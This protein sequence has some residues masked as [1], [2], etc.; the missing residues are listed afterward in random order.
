[1]KRRIVL[2]SLLLLF[3]SSIGQ[4]QQDF[5]PANRFGIVEGFWFPDVTCDLGVGW[6][7]IIFDWAQHQ[8]TGP[9]DWHTLNVDD[10]WLKAASACNREVVALLKTTPAWATDGTPGPGVP[11][12]LYLPYDDPGNTWG[13]FVSKTAAYYASRGVSRF[14]IWNEPD[15]DPETYGFEYEGDL[16]DYFRMVKVAYLAAR[17]ANPAARIHLAGTTYW[18]DVNEGRTPYIERLLDRIMQDPD[19]AANNYYFDVVSLHVYFRSETV[20]D[21]VQRVQRSLDEH[22]L[23]NKAIWINETN[24]APTDDPNWPVDRPVYDLDLSH[25]AS[26]LV[27]AVALALAADAERIAVYKLYDQDLPPNAESFGILSPANAQSRPAYETYHMLVGQFAD[28]TNATMAQTE[29]LTGVLLQHENGRQTL[30]AWARTEAHATVNIQLDDD[31]AYRTT[32]QGEFLIVP[33]QDGVYS[34]PLDAAHC[35]D[36]DGCFIGGEPLI[37]TAYGPIM[38]TEQTPDGVTPLEFAD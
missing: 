17:S 27:Q 33:T 2:L 26:Y 10:R 5:S 25:Q 28:V 32:L 4:A 34:V 11:R 7:R 15:I 19:A 23:Q 12:G 3:I 30:V 13:Q 38:I 8:P 21:L 29:T 24:A 31:K 9:E 36:V 22:G 6:E 16:E 1:M 20:Y 35:T 14:I 18:H 37:L